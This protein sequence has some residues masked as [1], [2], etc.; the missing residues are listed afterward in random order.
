MNQED[1]KYMEWRDALVT[2]FEASSY[3]E[4]VIEESNL[5]ET[6]LSETLED[7]LDSYEA[8]YA[9]G[10]YET[11]SHE[12]TEAAMTDVFQKTIAFLDDDAFDELQLMM[13]PA[14]RFLVSK[15]ICTEGDVLVQKMTKIAE[16]MGSEEEREN[17]GAFFKDF[18][19]DARREQIDLENPVELAA[20]T[21][22]WK[23]KQEL[24]TRF[25]DRMD[26]VNKD[27][28]AALESFEEEEKSIIAATIAHDSE[29]LYDPQKAQ[30]ALTK[31]SNRLNGKVPK[32]ADAFER[33]LQRHLNEEEQFQ[34]MLYFQKMA[35]K[36][37]HGYD[38]DDDDEPKETIRREEPKI[39]R[40]DPC[41]CGSGKKYKKCHGK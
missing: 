21:E 9:E 3:F 14:L 10:V 15:G 18:M 8:D 6:D 27:F 12:G 5:S 24:M 28:M 13:P 19:D 30:L 35:E 11:W 34:V 38:D 23:A 36:E 39:G 16:K 33:A 17:F 22:K 32:D 7:L 1:I 31:L 4:A 2:E 37:E 40:N 29:H 25:Y 26:E 20:F 41:P